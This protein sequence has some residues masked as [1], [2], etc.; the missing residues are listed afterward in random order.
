MEDSIAKCEI[1]E[2]EA[3][4]RLELKKGIMGGVVYVIVEI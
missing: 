1:D 3:L 4:F 2:K